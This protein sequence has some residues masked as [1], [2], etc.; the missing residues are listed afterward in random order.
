MLNELRKIRYARF[1]LEMTAAS[2]LRLPPYKGSTF[3]GAFGHTFKQ[4]V[5][6]KRDLDCS[7]CLISDRCVYYYVFETPSSGEG[8]KDSRG[9]TLLRHILLSLNHPRKLGKYTSREP[10]CGSDWFWWG[11]P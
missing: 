2:Q 3:R 9:Y 8:E 6:V 5:C 7:T 1:R 4:L 10:S 11:V